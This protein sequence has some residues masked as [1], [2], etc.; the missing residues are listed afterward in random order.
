MQDLEALV[1]NLLFSVSLDI[2]LE[3]LV[4]GLVSLDWV[5]QV[6]LIDGFVLSQE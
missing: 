4:C 6:I 1:P 5:A 3:E 2:I